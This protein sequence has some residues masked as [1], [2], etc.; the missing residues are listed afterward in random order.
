MGVLSDLFGFFE[1]FVDRA[2]HVER[3]FRQMI[4]LASHNHL[5]AANRFGQAHILA[6]GTGKH[7][8]DVERLGQKTLDLAGTG[9]RQLVFRGQLV[10]AQNRNKVAQLLVALQRTLHR[11][12]ASVVLFT[13]H[14][15]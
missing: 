10:Q 9:H 6:G 4:A 7:F 8:G 15:R 13:D 1:G 14:G 5:E 12:G 3:L 2:D 11:T